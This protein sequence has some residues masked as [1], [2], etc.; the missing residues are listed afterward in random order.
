MSSRIAFQQNNRQEEFERPRSVKVQ[1]GADGVN[2]F[3][4]PCSSFVSCVQFAPFEW[5]KHVLA[6]EANGRITFAE[7]SL[8][9]EN[10]FDYKILEEITV[11]LKCF[12]IAFSPETN[13]A[14]LNKSL[15]FA[16]TGVD[17]LI[18]IYST[19]V[20]ASENVSLTVMKEHESFV[21]DIVFEPQTGELLASVGDDCK[22]CLWSVTDGKLLETLQLTSPGR[23][24]CWHT[25]E[26]NKVLLVNEHLE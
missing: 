26:P 12:A 13:L 6:F 21:N 11:G 22:C 24:V 16:T 7:L 20:K 2:H 14:L 17:K 10:E 18:R 23:S 19:T 25:S 4:I 5:C 1:S 8:E 9:S 3:S 15:K